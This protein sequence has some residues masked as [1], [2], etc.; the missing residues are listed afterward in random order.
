MYPL[1]LSSDRVRAPSNG[2]FPPKR[3][4][5]RRD[6]QCPDYVDSGRSTRR[7]QILRASLSL[8]AAPNRCIGAGDCARFAEALAKDPL[9]L[10]SL[11]EFAPVDPLLG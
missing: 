4:V 7:G 10:V 8:L 3:N 11:L 2:S 5:H 9:A 1:F 6:L